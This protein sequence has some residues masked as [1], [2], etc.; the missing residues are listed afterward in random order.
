LDFF[1]SF[2]DLG[3]DPWGFFSLFLDH[4]GYDPWISW[5]SLVHSLILDSILGISLVCSLILMGTTL[6]IS[7]ISLVHSLTLGSI[8]GISLIHGYNP[9]DFFGSFLDPDVGFLWFMGT[10]LEISLVH[11]LILMASILGFLWFMGTTLGISLVHSLIL[12]ASIL[13]FLWFMGTTLGISL[14]HFLVRPL[15]FL[16]FISWYDPWDFFGS[17]LDPD[18]FNPWISLVHS[19]ILMGSISKNSRSRN[20]PIVKKA[21]K[22]Q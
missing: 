19:L 17:F 5:I 13:G 1:G 15:G 6:G 4:D 9:W 21:G 10:T 7:W 22:E 20:E 3:F 11:S 12:M 8:L 14:V 2:L 16:W 18:G